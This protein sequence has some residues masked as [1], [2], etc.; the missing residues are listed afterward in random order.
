MTDFIR[1]FK[2]EGQTIRKAPYAFA[3]LAVLAFS[4]GWG[5]HSVL[6]TPDSKMIS[7][8]NSAY[9]PHPLCASESDTKKTKDQIENFN[10]EAKAAGFLLFQNN[11][12]C[13][14]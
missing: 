4:A 8:V 12:Y 10:S 1:F 2:E 9:T 6:I 5:L 11:D 14:N 13:K 3:T 7:F